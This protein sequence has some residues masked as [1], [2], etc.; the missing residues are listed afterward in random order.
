MLN[1][2]YKIITFYLDGFLN[3]LQFI[4][5]INDLC[6]KYFLMTNEIVWTFIDY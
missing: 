2:M 6:N 1:S 4:E 5:I 3:D